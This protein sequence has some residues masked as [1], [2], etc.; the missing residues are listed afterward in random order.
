MAESLEISWKR[1]S[2][3]GATIV[4]SILLAFAIDAWWDERVERQQLIGHLEL[5][6]AELVENLTVAETAQKNMYGQILSSNR[7]LSA[8]GDS[9]K[10]LSGSEFSADL[11]D[12]FGLGDIG[13]KRHNS[14]NALVNSDGFGSIRSPGLIVALNQTISTIDEIERI[15]ER[16]SNIY[17]SH[18]MPMLEQHALSVTNGYLTNDFYGAWNDELILVTPESPFPVDQHGLRSDQVWNA[19]LNW[20]MELVEYRTSW[21][22]YIRDA[23]ILIEEIDAEIENN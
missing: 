10:D 6:R 17:F 11:M 16:Q 7:V 14:I 13:D 21:G 3:E 4:V 18:I 1:I 12:T 20:K 2:I 15:L 22:L 8:L 23:R 5:I 19:I 9:E